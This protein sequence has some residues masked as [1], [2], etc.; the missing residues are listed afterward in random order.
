MNEPLGRSVALV[1]ATGLVGSHCLRLLEQDPTVARIAVFVR[2]PFSQVVAAKTRVHVVDFEHPGQWRE[3]LRVD[4][5]ISALGT[6]IKKAGSQ[7]AFRR[8]DF[9]Y[10][11]AIAQQARAMGVRHFLLVSAVDAASSSRIFYNRVKGELEAAVLSMAFRSQTIVRPSTLIGD[12]AEYRLIERVA[13]RLAFLTPRKY[14]PVLASD[15]ANALVTAARRDEPG[16]R[17]IESKDIPGEN[18]SGH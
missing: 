8:V 13:F 11:C 1:G 3:L 12:R 15:V 18:S 4:Q 2:R 10:P 9:E 5:L 17:I 16:K 7:P 6:T 14:K